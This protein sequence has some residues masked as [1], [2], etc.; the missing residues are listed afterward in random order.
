MAEDPVERDAWIIVGGLISGQRDVEISS[1][2][3]SHVRAVERR[4]AEIIAKA[5]QS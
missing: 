2:Y 1:G 5:Q 4:V 3:P